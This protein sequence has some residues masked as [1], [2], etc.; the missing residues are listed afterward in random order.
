MPKSDI[1][2]HERTCAGELFLRMTNMGNQR[3]NFDQFGRSGAGY[4]T[5]AQF[6]D[7]QCRVANAENSI[8]NTPFV[9]MIRIDWD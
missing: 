9:I 2:I 3:Q 4:E 1:K 8:P 5:N 6:W 7:L